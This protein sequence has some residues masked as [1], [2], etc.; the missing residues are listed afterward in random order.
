MKNIA[1]SPESG[2]SPISE[3]LSFDDVLLVPRYSEV[4]PPQVQLGTSLSQKIS[5]GIP[6]LSAAMDKVTESQTAIAMARA[7][8]AGIIH[9]S[10]SVEKQVREVEKVKK[11]ESGMI[12]DP[13]TLDLEQTVN[14]ALHL[15]KQ[16]SI[17]GLPIVSHGKLAGLVTHRDLRFEENLKRPIREVM[18][19]LEKLVIASESISHQEA[20]KIMH[21]HRVEK[22]PVADASGQLKGLITIKD[23]E[24]SIRFPGANRDEKG[25]LRVGAAVGTGKEALER[26][27]ALVGA[28]VDFVAIDTAHG[29]S[30]NVVDV[31]K[32][33][34]SHFP[35]LVVVAGNV[36][37]SEGAEVLC[38]AGAD[39][40]KVGMGSGSIC[41]TRIIAGVGVPQF[42]AIQNCAR[43]TRS[44][45]KFLI[46]DGGIRY[47]GD[48]VKA[49]GAGADVV[50]IG[51]LLAGTDE[52]PGETIYY[53]GRT[54]KVY[55]G[56]GSI[57]ALRE[58]NRDRYGQAG[59]ED[60]DL[61]P[62]GIEGMVPYKGELQKVLHQLL[63][64]IRAGL[65]YLGCQ[66]I[67]ELREKAEFVKVSS[68]GLRESHV[69][70]VFVTKEAPNYRPND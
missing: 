49:L 26:I 12:L 62:E 54:Y 63:G 16:F 19:P 9:R 34:K 68:L 13:V 14:D 15:M 20:V 21:Q 61:I 7:G 69:H 2:Y 17:S 45:G 57:E 6:I 28:G 38:D 3:S 31:L 24:K 33:A 66:T 1:S 41:T 42:S 50:M 27:Q 53:Q 4:V 59:V 37:T 64:G 65:G 29:A 39:A 51:S 8:G 67:T 58:G 70:D 36:A 22:L 44:R 46:A 23:I 47:S 60:S 40:I 52:S 55:R 5:L 30:K 56:M 25:R 18:T 10:F 35:D 48:I 32:W 11:S 43:V